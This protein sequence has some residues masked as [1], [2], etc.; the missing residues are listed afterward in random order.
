[1]YLVLPRLQQERE[2]FWPKEI[3]SAFRGVVHALPIE[4]VDRVE[5]LINSSSEATKGCNVNVF[6]SFVNRVDTFHKVCGVLFTDVQDLNAVLGIVGSDT[7]LD[8]IKVSTDDV[9]Q[10]VCHGWVTH[11]VE[12]TV[13]SSIR[14]ISNAGLELSW[15]C[16]VNQTVAP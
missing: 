11:S 9:R 15:A 14:T 3:K 16:N 8:A 1:M 7:T 13:S 5:G 4:Y 10:K 12:E 2:T 6:M